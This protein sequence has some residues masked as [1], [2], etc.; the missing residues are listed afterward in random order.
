MFFLGTAISNS[1]G[2][3]FNPDC[4]Q[5]N[6][7]RYDCFLQEHDGSLQ[8]AKDYEQNRR[9]ILATQQAARP[10]YEEQRRLHRQQELQELQQIAEDARKRNLSH[11]GKKYQIT[12]GLVEE[13]RVPPFI[14]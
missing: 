8:T 3:Q 5:S 6:Q 10:D 12:Y 13:P 7:A 2:Q 4:Y 11:R 14:P 9:S 1:L